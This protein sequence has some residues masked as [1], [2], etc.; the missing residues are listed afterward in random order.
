VVDVVPFGNVLEHGD[1]QSTVVGDDLYDGSP[2]ADDLFKDEVS[3]GLPG[4]SAQQ[5][6]FDIRRERAA[7]LDDV[8]E[9]SGPDQ[10]V[11]DIYVTL[12]KDGRRSLDDQRV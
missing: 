4:L 12:H 3:E 6:S 1:D 2:A 11:D 7:G 9:T 10:H 8:R 5:S